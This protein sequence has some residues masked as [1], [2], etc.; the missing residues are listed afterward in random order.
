MIEKPP[1]TPLENGIAIIHSN[2]LETLRDVVEHWL[3]VH[4]LA[5]LENE[6]FLVQS[7][8]MGQWLKQS[9]AQNNSLGIA[10]GMTVQ[11]PSLFIWSVYRAVLGQQIPKQQLLA[12]APLTWRLYRLLP[13]LVSQPEFE[14]L[15]TFL[16]EDTSRRKRYQLAEQLADLFDQYQV[17]RSD[18]IA[19]WAEGHDF[20]RSPH[21]EPLTLGGQHR[22]QAALWRAVMADLNEADTA[23]ASRALVHDRFMHA[24]DG[25][26]TR[27]EGLPRRVILFGLSSL[28]QQSLEVVAKL[29]KFCQIVL[30]I[31]N[32]CRY[33]W[34]DI[35]EDK[36]LLKAE[37]RR[38]NYKSGMSTAL[39]DD[40]LHL[41]AN[42]LLAAW[43]KQGRDYIRL[44]DHF[45]ET[46]TYVNWHWPDN[47]IDL[48]NNYGEPGQRSLLNHLQQSILDLEPIPGAPVQINAADDS[49]TFHIAHSPQREVEI[50][51]DQLLARFNA[52]GQNGETLFPRD[53]IVMVPDINKYAPH[54]LAVFGQ[55]KPDDPRYIPFSLT[56]QQQ[57]GLNP[58]LVAVEALLK[59]PES[60]FTVSEFLALLEVPAFRERFAID[61]SAVPKLHQWIE[62]SGIRWGLNAQQRTQTVAMPDHLDANTWQFGL[63]RM[64]LG[65]AVGAGGAFNDIEPYQ[66]IGGLDA[67]WLGSLSVCLETLE[68][69]TRLLRHEHNV[70]TWQ[71]TLSALLDDF[72]SAGNERD[73]KMLETLSRTLTDWG[74]ICEQSGLTSNDTL[75]LVVVREAWLTEVDEPSLHRRFLSG[76][77][78]FCTLMPMRAI[79]F[80]LICLLGM[81][82]GDYPRTQH[83]H[84]FDLMSQ[85]GQY[86]PGD[87][88]RRQ[89]DQYLFLE[90]LLSARDQLYISWVGRSIRD[91]SERPPS[92]LVS[93]LRDVLAQGWRLAETDRLLLEVLTVEHP[94]QPF[95]LHYVAKNRDSRL[96]TYAQEWYEQTQN[97]LTLTSN[98]VA[99]EKTFTLNLE[100]LARFMKAPVK[101]FCLHT[102]KF[103][104]DEETVTSEDNEP[105]SFNALESYL[106]AN[107]L[108]SSLQSEKP[109]NP[110]RFFENQR[111]TMTQKGRL[112]YGGF[113]RQAFNTIAEPVKQAWRQYQTLLPDWPVEMAPQSVEFHF[114]MDAGVT[115]TLQGDLDHLRKSSKGSSLS[116]LHLTAQKLMN[117]DKIKYANL[118]HYWV[119][120]LATCASGMAVQSILAGAD[121]ELDI[122]PLPQ[123]DALELLKTL[124][125]AWYQGMQ[126]PL[127]VAC[128]TAFAWLGAPPVS[129]MAAAQE[130]YDGGDWKP[131]EVDFDPYLARFFPTFISLNPD[132]FEA[133]AVLLYQ[134]A[135]QQ[136]RQ[137]GGP[138]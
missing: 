130:Q 57:R 125:E 38:Q 111:R 5:P 118:L 6:V 10:A 16:A 31:P 123:A 72:F 78:N 33:Y 59:L 74:Q 122:A 134:A 9:L 102:L 129:A 119:Q 103:G 23:F 112:P 66:E 37:R 65:F 120:H 121:T 40:E 95:S 135:F 35:I 108:L 41:H 90:A 68:K 97:K 50:L 42:P 3:Q 24:I 82:D 83:G 93:Q 8:G 21:G 116:M 104:F 22:W 25:I 79:P 14:T 34:A 64:L 105:F 60:R 45:D 132:L 133:W 131:G 127:P 113:A 4:P 43:G 20:L 2:Q 101:A 137:Q 110:E 55:V 138:V 114:E 86:R 117:S 47:K 15:A 12:K 70:E 18:W 99:D 89:D 11:L 13:A 91:N 63:R 76:R 7:N 39:S 71:Q 69:Y 73:R 48:F 62:E 84:S 53:I 88:S 106:L 77:V 49:L 58:L 115:I 94:L 17:Y 98:R 80:R 107:E 44:L 87:R 96:F 56:D 52:S 26:D 92:V 19:D 29:G 51:H 61:E 109:A 85:R 1:C 100:S 32:P 136:I 54:I 124:A 30:F 128:R 28:P 75:P 36:E 46:R 126:A 81:N 67:K 27:P